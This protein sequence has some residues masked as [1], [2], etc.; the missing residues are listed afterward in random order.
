[1]SIG[2]ARLLQSYFPGFEVWTSRINDKTYLTVEGFVSYILTEKGRLMVIEDM[3]LLDEYNSIYRDSEMGKHHDSLY[4]MHAIVNIIISARDMYGVSLIASQNEYL[5]IYIKHTFNKYV[6]QGSVCIPELI[7][8]E[9]EKFPY[10]T[11]DYRFYN[12]NRRIGHN[13]AYY[14]IMDVIKH[15]NSFSIMGLVIPFDPILQNVRVLVRV[16]KNIPK[17]IYKGVLMEIMM[18]GNLNDISCMQIIDN[19]FETVTR[20]MVSTIPLFKYFSAYVVDKYNIA[21]H[22]YFEEISKMCN[23]SIFFIKNNED[24]LKPFAINILKDQYCHLEY[25]TM[26]KRIVRKNNLWGHILMNNK[27]MTR[28]FLIKHIRKHPNALIKHIHILEQGDER[29]FIRYRR[30]ID[31]DVFCRAFKGTS[32]DISCIL[33]IRDKYLDYSKKQLIESIQNEFLK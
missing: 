27:N 3:K 10:L 22:G 14:P 26:N 18:R 1:M 4:A 9:S 21:K 11:M 25:V 6:K 31:W 32:L 19:Y 30:K 5:D 24:A 28:C 8:I 33:N 17:E 20:E 13:V 16:A 23:I 12:S 15:Y 2:I 29:L 7:S